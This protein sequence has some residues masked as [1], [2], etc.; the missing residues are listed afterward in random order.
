MPRA[1]RFSQGARLLEIGIISRPHGTSGEVK[2]QTS[3]EYLTAL[4][5]VRKV[6]LGNAIQ[7]T[8][9]LGCRIHQNALLLQLEGVQSR[10]DAESLRGARVQVR[11]SELPVLSPGE[12][13][14]FQLVGMHVTDETGTELGIVSDILATGSNDVYVVNTPD[15]S[16][17]LLPAIESVIRKVDPDSQRMEVKVPEGLRD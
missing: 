17:L 5:G 12:Y 3:P 8:P 4:E 6:Y 7:G 16:E 1:R 11:T 2:V 14:S 10:N 15:G 9:V 13:Y